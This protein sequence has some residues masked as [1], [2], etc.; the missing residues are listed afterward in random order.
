M[1]GGLI[2]NARRTTPVT[3]APRRR[4]RVALTAGGSGITS[5]RALVEDLPGQPG[6]HRAS[7]GAR[8]LSS[9]HLRK[10][11]PD[12]AVREVC[13]CGPPALMQALAQPVRA[14]GVPPTSRHTERCAL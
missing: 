5:I 3:P 1:D 4:A 13:I 2:N 7:E 14:A 8:L 12:I 11:L 10:L 9:A 6:D